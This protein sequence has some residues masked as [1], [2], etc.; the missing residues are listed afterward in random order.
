M[1]K[2]VI[3]VKAPDAG[4]G[5]RGGAGVLPIMAYTGRPRPKG[6]PFHALGKRKVGDFTSSCI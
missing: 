6:V 5:G 4:E 1:Q 2:I 3:V